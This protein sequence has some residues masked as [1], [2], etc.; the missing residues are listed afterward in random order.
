M[1]KKPEDV[2]QY[3][4]AGAKARKNWTKFKETGKPKFKERAKRN[5]DEQKALTIKMANPGTKIEKNSLEI[6]NSF[7]KSKT[8]SVPVNVKIATSKKSKKK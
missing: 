4:E 5:F 1:R 8:T 2:Q 7:N 3:V 6:K